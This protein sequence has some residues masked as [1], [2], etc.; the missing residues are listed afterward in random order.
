MADVTWEERVYCIP[1]TFRQSIC[2]K[3]LHIP[4]LYLI[5]LVIEDLADVGGPEC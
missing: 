3:V 4:V 1:L 5:P 2:S